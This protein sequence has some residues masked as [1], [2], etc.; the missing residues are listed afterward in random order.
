MNW[1]MNKNIF[2]YDQIKNEVISKSNCIMT[3]VFVSMNDDDEKKIDL[4]KDF[5]VNDKIM[6]NTSNDCVFMHCLPA[7]IGMEV[8]EDVIKSN[9]SI[10]WH[11]AYNRLIAQKRLMKCINW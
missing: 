4:L 10:V 2:L 6:Q 3:D 9:K 5:Q 7:K 8:S 11:Q 1:E